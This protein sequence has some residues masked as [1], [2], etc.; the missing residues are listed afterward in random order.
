MNNYETVF[1][2]TPVLSE[3]QVEEAVNKYVDLI[4]EKNCEIVARE[5][6]GLKKLAYPI[7]LKKNGFYTLI[8]FKGEG[9]VV[10]DLELAFKRD[11]RVIRYLTTKLDK[12]AV[13]YA[14]TRRTKVK[15]AKA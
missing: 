14:V 15:A 1:I 13:E 12:H 7:Q 5:N 8:E 2:L 9:S 3:S 11:E 6:W 4:K 10:A